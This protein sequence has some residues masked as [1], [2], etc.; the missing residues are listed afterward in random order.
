MCAES[1]CPS[2]GRWIFR[3][4]RVIGGGG[5][6]GAGAPPP[7][8]EPLPAPTPGLDF[9]L[10]LKAGFG[11]DIGFSWCFFLAAAARFLFQI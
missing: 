3:P 4:D 2:L 6:G 8:S 7:P 5:G 10:D 11:L 9:G 1:I